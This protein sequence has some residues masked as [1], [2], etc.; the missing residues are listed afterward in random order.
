M[1]NS[2]LGFS[3]IIKNFTT[4]L[5]YLHVITL[6]QIIAQSVANTEPLRRFEMVTT[7]MHLL[8]TGPV[9]N[10]MR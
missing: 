4:G 2:F 7:P 1:N 6:K 8:L 3:Q 9:G 5:L 10:S